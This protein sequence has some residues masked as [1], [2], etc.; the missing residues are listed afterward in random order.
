MHHGMQAWAGHTKV[1]GNLTILFNKT[2]KIQSDKK[3]WYYHRDFINKLFVCLFK[4]AG[5][6]LVVADNYLYD[7]KYMI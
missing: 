4:S 5:E 2:F 1:H 6:D 7:I 3:N